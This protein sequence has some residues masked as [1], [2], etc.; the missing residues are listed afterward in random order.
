MLLHKLRAGTHLVGLLVWANLCSI[1]T[2]A[3]QDLRGLLRETR[4][5]SL[6]LWL[7][8]WT[9]LRK[10]GKFR[11]ACWVRL[12]LAS[13]V[14]RTTL[15][16][17]L[18]AAVALAEQD[19]G[20][21][22]FEQAVATLTPHIEAYPDHPKAAKCHGLRSLAHIWHGHYL[23]TIEDL[24]RCVALRPRYA[25]GFKYLANLAQVHGI[26]GEVQLA[27]QAMAAQCGA[28]PT[29]DPTEFLA[30]YLTKRV[31]PHLRGLPL[32]GTVGVMIGAYHNAVGH[33]ILDPFHFYNLFRHRFDH[34]VLIHPPLTTY[35]RPTLLMVSILDQYLEQIEIE[36]PDLP[37]FAWQNLGELRLPGRE[38]KLTFLCYN[39][40]ALNRM[41]Y[42]ARRDPEHPMSRGRQ[43]LQLPGKMVDR[44]ERLCRKL[45]LETDTDRPIVVV[46]TREHGYHRLRGQ[47]FRNADIRN[48]VPALRRLIDRGYLVVRIGDRRMTSIHREV[49][50][51]VEL[52]RLTGYDPVLDAYFLQRCQFMISCQSGPC[53]LARAMG[54]PNLVVNAVYNH[55]TLPEYNELFAFKRYLDAGGVELGVEESLRRCAH[56][57]DRTEHFERAGIHLADTTAEEI[58]AAL[59]EM[60]A[61]LDHP[62]R[63][64]TPAQARVRRIMEKLGANPDP[65][66]PLTHRMSNYIGHALPECRVSDAV[67]R[68]RPGF[69]PQG[70]TLARVA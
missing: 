65:A 63:P 15:A 2:A 41:A 69:A 54:K 52:P 51:L 26:R 59:V 37:A 44:A 28:R 66:N 29:D 34:L 64:D 45:R 23:E 13:G 27:R 67:C 47:A 40:W 50:G 48:Y 53:S 20:R 57:F 35:S 7:A 17:N 62:N 31:Y 68:L 30:E 4:H 16:R 14:S 12:C 19:I 5:S 33:A 11:V 22:K 61:G 56:L 39:Y 10:R 70:E 43:Y 9:G 25:R 36:C 32:A 8:V 24:K 6:R 1:A 42:D 55:T 49:P 21:Q 3:R 60:L 58:D 46:H 38:Q 18:E